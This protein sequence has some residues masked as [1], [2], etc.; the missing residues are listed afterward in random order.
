MLKNKILFIETGNPGLHI[1]SLFKIPRLGT[2][3]LGTIL[4]NNGYD[5]KIVIEEIKPITKEDIENFDII[6]ISSLTSSAPRSYEIARISKSLNKITIMGG[7]HVTFVPEEALKNNIDYVIRGE[8]ETSLPKF[9]EELN[10]DHPDFSSIP[11]LSY[12]ENNEFIH[13]PVSDHHIDF[14]KVP[15]PDWTIVD[16][17]WFENSKIKVIPVMTS[18]GCPFHCTFCT[19]TEMFGRQYRVRSINNVINE[20]K[21]YNNKK[22]HIF[23]Y[24]DNFT[25]DKEHT[26]E[27]LRKMIENNFQFTWSTQVRVDITEDEE[28]LQLMKQSGCDRVYIGFE[29]IN[30]KSLKQVKKGQTIEKIKE[31]IKKL[32]EKNISIHGMFIL[33]ISG[34]NEKTM[35]ETVKF[36]IK[37]GINTAQFLILTPLPG[38]V[39]YKKLK[40]KNKIL[41]EDY[42]IY[43]AHHVVISPE[44]IS[45]YSLQKLQLWAHSKFYSKSQIIKK[46]IKGEFFNSFIGIYA[47]YLQRKW[48]KEN[49]TFMESLKLLEKQDKKEEISIKYKIK[50]FF[51]D[52][53]PSFQ[54]PSFIIW[55]MSKF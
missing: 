33:G 55:F 13:N 22:N 36:A 30:P 5:V 12:I 41:F 44:G 16:N 49:K 24:D 45:P 31:C 46:F 29:S 2:I 48:I 50:H 3:I 35:K 9:L 18:R 37:N 52:T 7:P 43:D 6:A 47:S 17:S 10:K 54:M 4:K 38:T 19:V 42:S 32:K 8:A 39:E 11:G 1:F 34:E 40:E 21:L 53:L 25:A 15:I 20:L 26:K 23:F 28:L 14:D 51:H 27:L